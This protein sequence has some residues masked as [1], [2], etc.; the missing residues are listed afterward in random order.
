MT[1]GTFNCLIDEERTMAFAKAIA[2]TVR[3]GDVVVD[4]GTGSGVLAMLAARAGAKKVYAIEIDRSNI[5]T[6][7]AVFRAN[8]LE[9]RIVLIH[10]DVCKVDL[11]EKVDVIIGEMIATALIE[12]LQVLA[13]NNMLRFAK[14]GRHATR[15]LLSG[16]RT[17]LDLVN[18]PETYYGHSF[19]IV[20]YEYSDMRQL[21]S[22]SFSEKQLISDVD[23]TRINTDLEVQQNLGITVIRRGEINGLRLNGET[24]FF[25]GSTLGASYAY[26]YPVI[27]PIDT[28]EVSKGQVLKVKIGYTICG[29]MKTLRYSVE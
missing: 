12:E 21:K 27:L 19:K 9:D 22:K 6:L 20:R 16:Y 4:M 24:R 17:Y 3:P 15:V 14:R 26:S 11:P 8:G 25:D 18:N 2:A 13:T 29:G 23:F 5:A 7:D 28:R 1:E 10:G